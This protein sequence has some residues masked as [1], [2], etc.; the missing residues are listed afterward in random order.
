MNSPRKWTFG[1]RTLLIATTVAA[2]STLGWT[3][4]NGINTVTSRVS[5]KSPDNQNRLV[6]ETHVHRP[7]L[8]NIEFTSI[9]TKVFKSD[10]RL[11]FFRSH[12]INSLETKSLVPADYNKLDP[13]KCINWSPDSKKV[14]YPITDSESVTIEIQT[15][16]TEIHETNIRRGE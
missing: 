5:V 15:G 1:I 10:G 13:E 7:L 14:T 6:I 3:Y 9:R 4:R 8:K 16:L 2:L 12:S 11:D